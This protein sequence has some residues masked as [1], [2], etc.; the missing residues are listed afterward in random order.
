ML[1]EI[2]ALLGGM[3]F[4]IFGDPLIIGMFAVG[5]FVAA[6]VLAG[7]ISAD[8]MLVVIGSL[9]LLLA[10]YGFLPG[11]IRLLGIVV[12]AGLFFLAML[13]IFARK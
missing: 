12:I 3:F 2:V 7:R 9:L 4:D 8:I 10:T 11:Y 1:D 13:R 5:I 6:I